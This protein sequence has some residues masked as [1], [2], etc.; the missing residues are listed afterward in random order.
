[1]T[2]RQA[3]LDFLTWL[4]VRSLKEVGGAAPVVGG[5]LPVVISDVGFSV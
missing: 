3:G 1:M 2:P 4:Q 5:D